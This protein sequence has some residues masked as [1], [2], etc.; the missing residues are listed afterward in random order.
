MSIT[1][2]E[3]WEA[4][5]ALI[6]AYLTNPTVSTI[7]KV[8]RYVKIPMIRNEKR[9]EVSLRPGDVLEIQTIIHQDVPKITKMRF[10][11]SHNTSIA[12]DKMTPVWKTTKIHDWVSKN[13]VALMDD[14]YAEDMDDYL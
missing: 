10:V 6:R 11:C 7:Y 5:N 2:V 12:D 1:A 8:T 9:V 4:Y 14:D 13:C 3:Y